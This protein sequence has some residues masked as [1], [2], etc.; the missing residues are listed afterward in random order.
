[1]FGRAHRHRPYGFVWA[2]YVRRRLMPFGRIAHERLMPFWGL[3][4][5]D[6]FVCMGLCGKILRS[7]VGAVPVCPPA[8]P[9]KG[10]STIHSHAQCVYFWYGNAATR[11]FGRAHRHRP[12]GFVWADCVWAVGFVWRITC[13]TV[14]VVWGIAHGTFDVVWVDCAW[15][16]L[17]VGWKNGAHEPTPSVLYF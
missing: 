2:D 5:N 10:A 4:V 17:F 13:G 14:D 16:V 3:R 12:Y 9:C 6:Y 11:T 15:V 7:V 8:S 1:M